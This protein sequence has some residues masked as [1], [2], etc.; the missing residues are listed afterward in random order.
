[1]PSPQPLALPP[2]DQGQQDQ[3]TVLSGNISIADRRL[4]AKRQEVEPLQDQLHALARQREPLAQ[5]LQRVN[6]EIEQLKKGKKHLN[7]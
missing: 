4:A 2:R 5:E 6:A 1:M 3:L 7:F